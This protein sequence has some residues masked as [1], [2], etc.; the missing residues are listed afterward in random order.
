[1]WLIGTGLW[2]IS[3]PCVYSLGKQKGRAEMAFE[4]TESLHKLHDEQRAA[5]RR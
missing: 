4:M 3:A 2:L 1:M 5:E